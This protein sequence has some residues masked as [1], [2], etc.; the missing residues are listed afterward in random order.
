MARMPVSAFE[1]KPLARTDSPAGGVPG[2]KPELRRLA[3]WYCL[4]GVGW[5]AAVALFPAARV[6]GNFRFKRS[7]EGCAMR[8]MPIVRSGAVMLVTALYLAACVPIENSAPPAAAAPAAGPIALAPSMT[9]TPAPPP[10]PVIP[11][12]APPTPAAPASMSTPPAAVA[13]P[14]AAPS[15]S[16]CPPGAI[17][18]LSKPDF[19]GTPVPICHR[20]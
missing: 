20:L 1:F 12:P 17:A 6:Q 16:P 4:T 9:G 7:G 3:S 18:M 2:G 8:D 19:G 11:W 13:T 10:A 15:P 5:P 14:V